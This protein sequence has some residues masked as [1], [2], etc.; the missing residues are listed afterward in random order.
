MVLCCLL[1]LLSTCLDDL[2][3]EP[4]SIS[5]LLWENSMTFCECDLKILKTHCHTSHNKAVVNDAAL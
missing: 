5:V 4:V 2:L 1:C 3:N